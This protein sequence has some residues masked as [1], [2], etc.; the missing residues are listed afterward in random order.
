MYI[1]IHMPAICKSK[2]FCKAH[3]CL[4]SL[5]YP[6]VK[7]LKVCVFARIFYDEAAH[8]RGIALVP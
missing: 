6:A 8:L 4:I 5:I 3:R 2:L 7:L 1:L